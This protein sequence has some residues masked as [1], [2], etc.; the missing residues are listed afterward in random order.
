[1]K[2]TVSL[3]TAGIC[4]GWVALPALGVVNALRPSS[5]WFVVTR[6]AVADTVVG[7]PPSM[8]V[9]R[10]IKRDFWGEWT[11]SVR[12]L[13]DG[14]FDATCLATGRANYRAG[15]IYPKTFDLDRWT[16]PAR[17]ELPP[18]KYIV[19]TAWKI[20]LADGFND[21]F[22]KIDSNAFE[23]KPKP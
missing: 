4:A 9:E 8:H 14:S 18:G 22:L 7:V 1:M 10:E 5:D 12:R 11:V 3:W 2:V 19:E 16:R 20:D 17:C 21:K 15:A 23:V 6:V 13:D